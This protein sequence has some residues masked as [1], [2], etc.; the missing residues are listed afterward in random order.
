MKQW[1]IA[2][3]INQ[4]QFFQPLT[5]A[6]RD[7]QALRHI[8][9]SEAGFSPERCILLSDNSPPVRGKSTYPNR[10]NILDWLDRICRE[11]V[12]PGDVLWLFFSG[13]GACYQGQDYLMPLEGNPA[14]ITSTGIPVTALFERIQASTAITLVLLDI[15][16]SQ[17]AVSYEEVG[18]QTAQLAQQTGIATILSCQP[19]QFSHEVATLRQGLFTATLVEC[20]R[21]QQCTTLASLDRYLNH[22]LPELSE[23]SWQP[24]QQP[25]T[26]CQPG[27][28]H[29]VI[30]PQVALPST[31]GTVG[32]ESE[33]PS[34][35]STTMNSVKS[36]QP[37]AAAIATA[38][39]STT[40]G[41]V[42]TNGSAPVEAN[43]ASPP[44]ASLGNG[45]VNGY[46]ANGSGS[47]TGY[48][49]AT[50]TVNPSLLP[51]GNGHGMNQL[52]DENLM[53][54]PNNNPP[55]PSTIS[56]NSHTSPA[57]VEE[58]EVPD[59]KFWP[60]MLLWGGLLTAF[61]L[62]GVFW[63]NWSTF[64]PTQAVMAQSPNPAQP[65]LPPVS[66][67][68]PK[69]GTIV[70]SNQTIAAAPQS[71]PP[72]TTPV[73]FSPQPSPLASNSP[74]SPS[75]DVQSL[76]GSLMQ[77]LVR[78]DHASPFSSAIQDAGK[79]Q[80]GQ[81]GYEQA[82]QNIA[83]WSQAIYTIALQRAQRQ[84]YDTAVQAAVLVPPSQAELYA[85]ARTAV[86]QEWCPSLSKG[87]AGPLTLQ[88]AKKLCGQKS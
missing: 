70:A 28:L 1:A 24:I 75:I 86:A 45:K 48:S 4:Y 54:K 40:N 85:Q 76:D 35:F 47:P 57:A 26:I 50:S 7:A 25:L 71:V 33:L 51:N 10:E 59:A 53:T 31:N 63:R 88:E 19:G 12:Q 36:G 81:P 11:L 58:P 72:A 42:W 8:L 13:Y 34:N 6:Q 49:P 16:R 39:D 43:T 2:I 60:P 14:A 15:N 83:L 64:F 84:H 29:Q 21:H 30:L 46:H 18:K 62:V 32:T 44:I 74:I 67:T 87:S 9:A 23:H 78:N 61:L 41:K 55:S 66:S 65:I 38:L 73:E 82:Q 52:I 37:N 68:A 3:G 80:P 79:I 77:A 27:Q 56:A 69:N 17:G 22:R 20:L 5:Y